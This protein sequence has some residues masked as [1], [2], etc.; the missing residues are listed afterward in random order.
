MGTQPKVQ[1]RLTTPITAKVLTGR[2]GVLNLHM[3]TE[4]TDSRAS[5]QGDVPTLTMLY[6]IAS[7]AVRE[8]NY[9]I[10]FARTIGFPSTFL[11]TA[12]RAAAKLRE[13]AAAKKR[14]TASRRLT[15]RRKLVLCLYETLVQAEQSDMDDAALARFLRRLQA[16]FIARME[17]LED[18]NGGDADDDNRDSAVVESV[19]EG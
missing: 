16:D 9:G 11:D 7:G 19:E 17:A 14:D 12:E 4:T 15:A 1:H 2:P 8:T 5:V 3:K 6:K 13:D 10:E 18:G